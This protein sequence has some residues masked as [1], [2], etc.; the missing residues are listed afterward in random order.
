MGTPKKEDWPEG[1]QLASKIGFRFPQFVPTPL[2]SLI[3]NASEDAIAMM[4][5][6][7]AW[8]PAHRIT[9]P[10]SLNH[11]Y[12]TKYFEELKRFKISDGAMPT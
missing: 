9:A 2:E 10:A 12:F 11:P 8:N 5:Q 1:Y 4:T 6:S 7:L 3:T